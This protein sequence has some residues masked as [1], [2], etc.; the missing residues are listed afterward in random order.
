MLSSGEKS[1]VFY[2]YIEKL[3]VIRMSTHAVATM[4]V[5]WQHGPLSIK[6]VAKIKKI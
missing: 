5:S 3:V 1:A 2:F 6:H 4:N